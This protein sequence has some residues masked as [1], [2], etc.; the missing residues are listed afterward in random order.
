MYQ[1]IVG[2]TAEGSTDYR[3]LSS[4]VRR[5]YEEL[6]FECKGDVEIAS[7]QVVK[8]EKEQ[9]AMAL[10]KAA[11]LGH[12]NFGISI[13]CVHADADTKATNERYNKLILPAIAKVIETEGEHCKNIVPIVPITEIESW[14]L[15]DKESFKDEIGSTESDANLKIVGNPESFSDPKAKIE[16][17][18]R[19]EDQ[20][21][22]RRR[23]KL[24]ISDLYQPLGEK[25]SLDQLKNLSSYERFYEKARNSLVLLNLL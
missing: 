5:T 2:L 21:R 1:L 18:I 4:L 19:I 11:Q 3:F 9:F 15:A 16:E 8:V 22:T 10:L 7:V 17:A 14:M 20:K 6:A 24:S 13:L 23:Q 12:S 25:C